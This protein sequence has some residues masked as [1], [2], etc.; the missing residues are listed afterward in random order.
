MPG[1]RFLKLTNKI[2]Q[3]KVKNKSGRKLGSLCKRLAIAI[4]NGRA[5]SNKILGEIYL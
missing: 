4:M 5:G 2:S 1:N 3:D